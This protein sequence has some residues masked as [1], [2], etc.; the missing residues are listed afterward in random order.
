MV[1][2]PTLDQVTQGETAVAS[3]GAVTVVDAQRAF[4]LAIAISGIRCLIAYVV[5]PF[6]VPFLGLAPGVGPWLGVAASVVAIVAN[7][8][9]IRRFRRSTHRMRRAVIVINVTVIALLVVML[10]IDIRALLLGSA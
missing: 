4:S 8:V 9:S 2:L 1:R 6:A 10:T 7:V 3:E 5:L